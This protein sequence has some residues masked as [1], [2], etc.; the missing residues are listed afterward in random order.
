MMKAIFQW[1][2]S[3]HNFNTA[4]ISAQHSA[5]EA[6]TTTTVPSVTPT[7]VTYIISSKG[8]TSIDATLDSLTQQTLDDWSA[9]VI[10]DGWLQSLAVEEVDV[11][12]EK[13]RCLHTLLRW[14]A[15][16]PTKL[17]MGR[18]GLETR[19]RDRRSHPRPPGASTRRRPV[20][21]VARPLARF[22]PAHAA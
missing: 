15:R 16:L 17:R 3:A 11:R 13:W 8:C 9:I 12:E 4:K 5:Q 20:G 7:F 18:R 1:S 6:A 19:R 10:L 21:R 22:R 2:F 14:Q